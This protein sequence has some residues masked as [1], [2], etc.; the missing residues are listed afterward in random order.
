MV[1]G[2]APARTQNPRGVLRSRLA[3]CEALSLCSLPATLRGQVNRVEAA[4]ADCGC[5]SRFRSHT[6]SRSGAPIFRVPAAP[7]GRRR[8]RSCPRPK[9][10]RRCR[11]SPIAP[12]A[13][14]A[15]PRRHAA[16]DKSLFD[17]IGVTPPGRD[18][19]GL[20]CG[21]VEH[22]EYPAR[23]ESGGAGRRGCSAKGPAYAWR[24]QAALVA[25]RG[26]A[27]GHEHPSADVVAECHCAKGTCTVNA[28]F[29]ADR[30]GRRHD[31][32]ARM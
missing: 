20:L 30:K 13:P 32:T 8:E 10:C 31:R 17:V 5:R 22:P 19:R 15:A 16:E 12:A 1:L 23:V 9:K 29:L 14:D 7:W 3:P 6:P 21:I 24:A 26:A 4:A 27:H 28:E 18:T 11:S 25:E 2:A